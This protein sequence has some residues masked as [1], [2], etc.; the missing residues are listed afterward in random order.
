MQAVTLLHQ[1][2]S[3]SLKCNYDDPK[4]HDKE[5]QIRKGKSV[6]CC[7]NWRNILGTTSWSLQCTF[8]SRCVSVRCRWW[9]GI[10]GAGTSSCY[11]ATSPE[12]AGRVSRYMLHCYSPCVG[13][14][15]AQS[16]SFKRANLKL[17][18]T[19]SHPDAWRRKCHQ[20]LYWTS[21]YLLWHR[22]GLSLHLTRIRH[23][24]YQVL[25]STF[26]FTQDPVPSC[27]NDRDMLLCN[28][29]CQFLTRIKLSQRCRLAQCT[30]LKLHFLPRC[31]PGN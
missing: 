31:S 4:N 10:L 23:T 9:H 1:V 16:P 20:K 14:Q 22:T 12:L 21:S 3:L 5:R 26:T 19:A 28:E 17:Y 25:I 7:E 29:I 27:S 2:F 30:L 24:G 11:I 6:E 13:E 15:N 8:C 18:M